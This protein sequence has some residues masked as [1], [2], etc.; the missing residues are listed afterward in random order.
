MPKPSAPVNPDDETIKKMRADG[1]TVGKIARHLHLPTEN[2]YHVL[3]GANYKDKLRS[4]GTGERIVRSIKQP[5]KELFVQWLSEAITRLESL[6]TWPWGA[7]QYTYFYS[8]ACWDL[9]DP[10][11]KADFRDW[12]DEASHRVGD[13]RAMF[14]FAR[15]NR[16]ALRHSWVIDQLEAWRMAGT[17]EAKRKLKQFMTSYTYDGV[18]RSPGNIL[19]N[20]RRD[21]MIYCDSL[22]PKFRNSKKKLVSALAEHHHDN[23]CIGENGI[24][25]ALK[26]Y[27]KA[28]K[29]WRKLKLTKLYCSGAL[30]R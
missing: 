17:P 29:W 24:K 27:N 6:P 12:G 23:G 28:Y 4:F 19:Q 13:D 16:D 22:R 18:K 10:Q 3:F 11:G 30:R 14:R 1:A 2:V 8:E 26:A 20:I 9:R 25:D 7:K 5:S 15:A 21:K